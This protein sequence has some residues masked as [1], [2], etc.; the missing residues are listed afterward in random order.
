LHR[1]SSHC[2]FPNNSQ[3]HFDNNNFDFF[4]F[5]VVR[6][7]PDLIRICNYFKYS[8]SDSIDL[9]KSVGGLHKNIAMLKTRN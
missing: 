5:L 2:H 3:V 9:F 4:L 7:M 8:D 1:V 6:M